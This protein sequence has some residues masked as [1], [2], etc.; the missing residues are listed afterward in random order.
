MRLW[1][2]VLGLVLMPALAVAQE[3]SALARLVPE[4]SRVA[5]K[6][7]GIDV[8]LVL[9]QPVPWRVRVLDQPPRLVLDVREVDWSGLGSVEQ[10]S[11]AVAGLRAGVVRQGWSRLVLEL[12]GPY[13]VAR[14]DMVTGEAAAKV[15]LHL[16]PAGAEAFAAAAAQPEPEG[17]ALPEIA[18]LPKPV[19]RGTG[20][21]VVVLDPGHGGIDPGAERDGY[22]EAGLMLTF[23]REL[24][25]LLLRDGGFLVILTRE[26][27]EF[28]PLESRISIAR[29]AGAHVFVSLHADAIAEGEAVGAT[30]YTLSEDASDAASQALAERHDRADLLSGVDLTAQ[31]DLVATILMDMARTET[32]PRIERLALALESAIKAEGLRMHRH[33]RQTAGFSVLKSPDIPSVLVELGFMSSARDLARLIDPEWRA[34]MALA[35]RDGLKAW[36]AEDAALSA[37]QR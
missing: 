16:A 25:D 28:V 21:V 35:L 37:L 1:V 29:A 17:W 11:D 19:P 7:G 2:L 20:P 23:A 9:S 24:K 6:S 31:D 30:I 26:E 18:D 10:D 3:L 36:A 32:G 27:D 13:L 15:R 33:P 8:E 34:K 22:S 4:Q 12:T 14:A 5:D